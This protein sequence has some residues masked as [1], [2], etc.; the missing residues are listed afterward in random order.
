M[1]GKWAFKHNSLRTYR[2]DLSKKSWNSE[3][4]IKKKIIEDTSN[5][6]VYASS[7]MKDFALKFVSKTFWC[8]IVKE[9]RTGNFLEC[10]KLFFDAF[11]KVDNVLITVEDVDAPYMDEHTF[12]VLEFPKYRRTIYARLFWSI[13]PGS[14][15]E[16]YITKY[17]SHY[18]RL[19]ALLFDVGKSI[20]LEEH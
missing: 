7:Q 9:F 8:I 15:K 5:K 10:I 16:P 1:G 13:L 12:L 2:S 20:E 19:I 4:S 17:P 14:L 6:L 3:I 11:E 18:D